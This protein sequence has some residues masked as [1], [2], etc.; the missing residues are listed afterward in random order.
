MSTKKR[1]DFQQLRKLIPVCELTQDNLHDLAAKTEVET[2]SQ[3]RTLFKK[4]DRDNSSFYLLS[5][6]VVLDDGEQR[7]TLSG[8]SSPARYPLDHHQPRQATA[9]A[10]TEVEYVRIDNDLLDILLTWDQNAG[11]MVSEIGVEEEAD[12]GIQVDDDGDWM[13]NLLRSSLFHKIPPTNIQAIFM[14]MEA[15]PVQAGDRI[16]TQGEE[17]DYYYYIKDGKATVTR[18]SSKSGKELKLAELETGDSF[19]EEALVSGA[20]RNADVTMQSAGVL[21]RL[22]KQDFDDLLKAP[23]LETLAYD[24]AKERVDQGKAVWLDVRLESEHNS[25]SLPGS[26]HIPLY[27]LRLK[28]AGLDRNKTYIVYCDTGRRSAS[29]AY[30]LS[31]RNFDVYVLSGGLMALKQGEGELSG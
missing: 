12:T 10:V 24:Q 23:V 3:G 16:I 30:L 7:K 1:V 13:T 9:T 8:G 31:E 29:A 19:G 11:Y 21:M 18:T 5:G 22:S 17:G 25:G 15:M 20:K 6:D 28:A 26:I 2:L 14:R 4:G 27:L